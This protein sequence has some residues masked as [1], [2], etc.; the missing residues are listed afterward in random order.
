MLL[1]AIMAGTLILRAWEDGFRDPWILSIAAAFC[2]I[3]CSQLSITLVNW[4][5]TL[6]IRPLILPRMDFSDGI[7]EKFRTLVVIPSL[8]NDLTELEELLENLEVRFLANRGP[9][10]HF[11]LLTDFKDSKTEILPGE[12]DLL[13][14]AREKIEELNLKYGDDKNEIFFIFHRPRKYNAKEKVWMG[15]E[16]KR[17]KLAEMNALLRGKD[18]E[19]FMLIVGDSTIYEQ[20]K[21]VITLDTDTQLPRD[22]AWKITGTM[23]HPMNHPHFSKKKQRVVEG[24]GILQPRVAVSLPSNDST[25]FARMH[26][27]EPGIDPYTR[28]VSDVYQDLFGEGSFIGK[29]IYDVDAFE[30][31]L[32][33]RF[34]ENRILSHDLLEGSYAR[35]GLLS[36]VQLY[37]AY[38]LRYDLDMKRRHRWIRGDWQ[39][40]SWLLPWF[41]A[42]PVKF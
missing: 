29:G 21:Y 11:A 18:R 35:C 6:I 22:A 1:A 28:A 23:A 36:D 5:S 3:G 20:V 2:L 31:A 24:Y 8:F 7:P 12:Y 27:N 14:K 33:N 39:I 32:G 9:N 19:K 13:L 26:G 37:E 41:P 40:A 25:P 4:V 34:P 30:K 16:R 38:P 17:G 15:F 10:I 42:L